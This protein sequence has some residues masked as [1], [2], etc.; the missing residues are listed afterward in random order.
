MPLNILWTGGWDSTFRVLMSSIVEERDVVPH[1]VIGFGRKSSLHELRAIA[2]I[3]NRLQK[4]DARAA[5]RIE[6]LRL[7]PINE[8]GHLPE[9][10]AAYER[11]A[12]QAPLGIQ[13]E[14]LARY[15]S[16]A[17][18]NDLELS[19]HRDDRAYAFLMGNVKA[20][21]EGTYKLRGAS[22]DHSIVFGNFSFPL[23][24]TSKIEMKA[25]AETHDF[26]SVLEASWFCHRPLG[27]QPCGICG[28]CIF[29]VEEGMAYRLPE[30]SLSRYYRAKRKRRI[31]ATLKSLRN[32][33]GFVRNK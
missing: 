29:T 27:K 24:E 5:N 32:S 4:I 19:I 15:A 12:S 3:R 18:V 16:E 11:F 23:L 26:I 1:Y 20:N 25:A 28:P 13:Y 6:K 10:T 31:S 33:I 8:I 9:V 7:T 14:W 2:E 21:A 17:K 22:K 30:S